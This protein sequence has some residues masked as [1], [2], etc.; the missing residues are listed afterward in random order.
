MF[1]TMSG[2]FFVGD[3]F[4]NWVGEFTEGLEQQHSNVLEA[5]RKDAVLLLFWFV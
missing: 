2:Q 1:S 3:D 5:V 4:S